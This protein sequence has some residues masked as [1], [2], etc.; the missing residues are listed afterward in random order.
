MR[1]GKFQPS[2]IVLATIQQLLVQVYDVLLQ[3]ISQQSF[4]KAFRI[5][6]QSLVV[7]KS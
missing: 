3:S 1:V 4:Q 2:H 6:M 7:V 5:P